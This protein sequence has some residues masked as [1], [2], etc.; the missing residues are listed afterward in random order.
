M[1]RATAAPRGR[2]YLST[3]SLDGLQGRQNQCHHDR[4]RRQDPWSQLP[5]RPGGRGHFR[6]L[7]QCAAA[8]TGM[9]KEQGASVIAVHKATTS[10]AISLEPFKGTGKHSSYGL[11]VPPPE[12]V[13]ATVSPPMLA[14]SSSTQAL[15]AEG[16]AG[17]AISCS[18]L[19]DVEPLR[20][21]EAQIEAWYNETYRP[22]QVS[23][24]MP[25]VRGDTV[26]WKGLK[27]GR[28]GGISTQAEFSH[29]V[30]HGV[31]DDNIARFLEVS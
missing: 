14:P 19:S 13:P 22:L 29:G 28:S 25:P 9:A 10:K 20:P 8:E 5:N 3:L 18:A 27:R 4:H 2:L 26:L 15:E 16:A 30:V 23:C 12:P 31:V 6:L 21:S 7:C 1:D 17:Q 11:L 24:R